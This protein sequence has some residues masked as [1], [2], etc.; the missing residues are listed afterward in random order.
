MKP[1][2]KIPEIY[3]AKLFNLKED[4]EWEDLGVGLPRILN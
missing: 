4:N 1:G 3:R 2:Y